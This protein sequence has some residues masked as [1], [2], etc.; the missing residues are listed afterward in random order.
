MLENS[1][2]ARVRAENFFTQ[3]RLWIN[4]ELEE[5]NYD[6]FA[7][8]PTESQKRICEFALK[9]DINDIGSNMNNEVWRS[10]VMYCLE[11]FL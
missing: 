9:Y 10:V 2:C 8:E 11:L 3:V 6:C 4:C 7:T 1:V 5:V